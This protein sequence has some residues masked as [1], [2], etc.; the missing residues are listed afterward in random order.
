MRRILVIA[1]FTVLA[2]V[3][4]VPTVGAAPTKTKTVT[5]SFHGAGGYVFDDSSCTASSIASVGTYRAKHLGRGTYAFRICL[6]SDN[7]LHA[8]GTFE[9]VTRAGAQLHGAID[10]DVTNGLHGLPVTITGGTGRFAAATGNLVL[11]IVMFNERNCTRNNIC[12]SWDER[13]TITG[14]ITPRP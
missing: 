6:T 2:L 5:G 13:G 10:T 7:A 8:V 11:D 1:A 3:G 4:S 9:L 12:L 14:T